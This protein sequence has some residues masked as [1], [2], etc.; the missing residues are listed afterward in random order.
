MSSHSS[1]HAR[2]SLLNS[3]HGEPQPDCLGDGDQRGQ[4]GIAVFGQSSIKAF[5]LDAGRLG[6]F[7]EE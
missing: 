1:L 4:T 6:D 7:G 3:F 5:A 2:L